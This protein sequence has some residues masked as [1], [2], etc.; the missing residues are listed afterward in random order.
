MATIPFAVQ[1]P[2]PPGSNDPRIKA[3]IG[4]LHVDATDAESLFEFFRDR[5]G[6][7]EAHGHIRR[8]GT[9]EQYRDTAF[10]ADANHDAND[11]ALSFETQGFGDGEWTDQQIATIKLVILWA[12]AVHGIPFR[13][14]TSWD[15][16][17]GGW[18]Y[19]TLFGAPSHWTPVAKSCPGP[20][21]KIQFH[22]I[23]QP[24]LEAGA[25]TEEDD[26]ADKATQEQLDRIEKLAKQAVNKLDNSASRQKAI[27]AA[28][29][30]ILDAPPA[31]VE[32]SQLRVR[33]VLA[34]VEA[35]V[36]EEDA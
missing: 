32:E 11:F 8:D 36:L 4:I 22:N 5:S 10:Q 25:P 29:Q 33:R 27:K 35:D 26:M 23:I 20:K 31:S 14:V 13:V 16:P 1:R 24:W 18:G 12:N 6:G 15:D 28:L 19:H 2:I 17:R 7:I 30:E 21:R 9:M 3:R 34:L